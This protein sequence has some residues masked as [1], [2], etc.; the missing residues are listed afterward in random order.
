MLV[1]LLVLQGFKLTLKERVSLQLH[2]V[3]IAVPS[4]G[5]NSHQI[6]LPCT[7]TAVYSSAVCLYIHFCLMHSCRFFFLM[8]NDTC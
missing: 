8:S 1:C 5:C 6:H 3:L 4:C 2:G 7:R